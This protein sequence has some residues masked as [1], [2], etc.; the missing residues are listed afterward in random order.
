MGKQLHQLGKEPRIMHLDRLRQAMVLFL[1]GA[2]VATAA[3]VDV[4]RLSE[5]IQRVDKFGAGHRDAV[6]A[7]GELQKGNGQSLLGILRSVDDAAP[8]AANWLRG[9]FESIAAR[10]LKAGRKLPADELQAF[11]K[12]TSH[13]DRARRLA[14]EWLAHVDATAPDRLLPTMLDDPS[15][16]L[17][18]DAI[19]RRLAE[20][21]LQSGRRPQ[22]ALA[23]GYRELLSHARD[24][25]QIKSITEKLKKT[26]EEVNLARHFGFVMQWKLVGPFDNTGGKGFAAVYPPEQ[27]VDFAATYHG[28]SS[29][30]PWEAYRTEDEYGLV[31]LNRALGKQM[32]AV[33]YAAAEFTS[34]REQP[35]ELRLGCINACKMWLNGELLLA[36]EVYHTGMEIDQYV[37]K[38][39]LRRGRNLI[40]VKVCQ[41]E[42]TEDW[43]QNWQFQLRVCDSRGTAV[44]SR[45]LTTKKD[46]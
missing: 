11:V 42:Q 5:A 25:D 39:T 9:A 3:E 23:A 20:I 45:E 1:L 38:G 13:G 29:K 33:A 22:T 7:V 14:Y 46:D 18:Y 10:E 17:R 43:A 28:K 41:N 26:G 27:Q 24:L 37:G 36:R 40:L 8:L 15:L 16:E 35:I 4:S 6:E 32:G 31:D 12:D 44:L 21:E 2:A 19:A 34:D 30:L